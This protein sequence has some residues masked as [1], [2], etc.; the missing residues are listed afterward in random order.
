MVEDASSFMVDELVNTV[1]VAIDVV[2]N[3]PPLNTS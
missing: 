2:L 3:L 1:V